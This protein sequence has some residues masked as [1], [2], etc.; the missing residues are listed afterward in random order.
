MPI[1]KDYYR[2]KPNTFFSIGI[3]N[4]YPGREYLVDPATYNGKTDDGRNFADLCEAATP[5][6]VS[7]GP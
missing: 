4:Y 5:E 6:N 7:F 2:I 3:A 1:V